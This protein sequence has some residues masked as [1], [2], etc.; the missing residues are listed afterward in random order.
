ML[1]SPSGLPNPL[2]L[3][4]QRT[5]LFS[6]TW[7]GWFCL[8]EKKKSYNAVSVGR[9]LGINP[10]YDPISWLC[11]LRKAQKDAIVKCTK[12]ASIPTS[13]P[14]KWKWM[15]QFELEPLDVSKFYLPFPKCLTWIP[16]FLSFCFF[17]FS[18][19]IMASYYC[20]VGLKKEKI[21]IS[22][23]FSDHS[24]HLTGLACY[25]LRALT[26]VFSSGHTSLFPHS[27]ITKSI[28]IYTDSGVWNFWPFEPISGW[29]ML[30]SN[31]SIRMPIS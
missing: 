5:T 9:G 12:T 26:Y 25:F 16:L 11:F 23:G 10:V 18:Y 8:E 3:P 2:C 30:G 21:V 4:L 1:L 22:N 13:F 24:Q 17:H 29:H 7:K 14:V 15:D 19:W 27:S 28:I 6:E 31:F 20:Q